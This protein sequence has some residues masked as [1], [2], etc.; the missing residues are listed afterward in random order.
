[1]VVTLDNST[2]QPFELGAGIANTFHGD[3]EGEPP[4]PGAERLSGR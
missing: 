2:G 4:R 3:V 1:M